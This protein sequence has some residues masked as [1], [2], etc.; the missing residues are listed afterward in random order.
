MYDT[1]SDLWQESKH[2]DNS[3]T[4]N[5]KTQNTFKVIKEKLYTRI[6]VST[7]K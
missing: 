1:V 6:S 3:V 4:N 7:G 5:L 2:M